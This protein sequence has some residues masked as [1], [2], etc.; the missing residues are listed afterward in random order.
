MN[1]HVRKSRPFDS[2]HCVACLLEG[3]FWFTF[4]NSRIP[5]ASSVL[6][7]GTGLKEHLGFSLDD[8]SGSNDKPA[9]SVARLFWADP[10]RNGWLFLLGFL[11]SQGLAWRCQRQAQ[12]GLGRLG[13]SL[14]H[15]GVPPRSFCPKVDRFKGTLQEQPFSHPLH[16]VDWWVLNPQLLL[17]P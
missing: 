9:S 13:S 10:P 2:S 6:G 14:W 7:A 5:F 8:F 12:G 15:S 4:T 1:R 17:K 16:D 3:S 11:E